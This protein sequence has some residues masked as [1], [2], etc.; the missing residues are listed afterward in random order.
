MPKNKTIP[1]V[2]IYSI[3]AILI[4]YFGVVFAPFT[5]LSALF[6][7]VIL[8]A[9]IY[10]YGLSNGI[11][12][13]LGII[14]FNVINTF[15]FADNLSI[16]G[17][18]YSVFIVTSGLV[19]GF[20][21]IK[22]TSFNSFLISLGFYYTVCAMIL[23][24]AI[25]YMFQVDVTAIVRFYFVETYNMFYEVIK[26]YNPNLL[27]TIGIHE[28]ELFNTL[29][30]IMPGIVPF[31]AIMLIVL[32]CFIQYAICKL[33]INNY[34]IKKSSFADGFDKFKLTFISAIVFLISFLIN[35][36]NINNMLCMV[37][38][39]IFMII[40]MLYIMEAAAIL[41]YKLKQSITARALRMLLFCVI[42]VFLFVISAFFTIVNI[43]YVFIFIGLTDS[44]FDYRK[45]GE[46]NNEN[47]EE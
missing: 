19:I 21:H 27:S 43:F 39:N 28:Y 23:F 3:L 7:P 45:L 13:G 42:V 5:I 1:L 33:V 34:L 26:L 11:Y 9:I 37:A 44:I 38:L 25:K 35:N 17:L 10:G 6:V 47:Y 46:N 2:Y 40:S 32:T 16:Y 14:V 31:M 18:I 41:Y 4:S 15:I 20:N 30:C 29:Y 8:S 24:A 36:S 22:K 12:V